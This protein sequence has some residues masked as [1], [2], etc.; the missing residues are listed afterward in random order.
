MKS[1]HGNKLITFHMI[2]GLLLI[3][4]QSPNAAA[5]RI[6]E[7]GPECGDIRELSSRLKTLKQKRHDDVLHFGRRSTQVK[8]DDKQIQAAIQLDRE[9]RSKRREN[10]AGSAQSN[11]EERPRKRHFTLKNRTYI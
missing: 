2:F 11:S 3:L 5:S 9:L 8:D 1:H 7:K 10:I 6:C 4:I